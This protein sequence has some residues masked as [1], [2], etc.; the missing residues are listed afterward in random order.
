VCEP[1]LTWLKN[2]EEE[3]ESDEDD[4]EVAVTFD[5]NEKK[6][7]E[8]MDEEEEGVHEKPEPLAGK[9]GRKRRENI[10]ASPLEHLK[11]QM[12]Q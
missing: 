5:D 11:I 2:A 10:E 4:E 12:F 8:W 7:S 3:E 9:T 1:F 6:P